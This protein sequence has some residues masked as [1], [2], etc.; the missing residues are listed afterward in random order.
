MERSFKSQGVD[1]TIRETDDKVELE[2][3]GHPISVTKIDER[4]H[5]QLAHMFRSFETVEEVVDTLLRNEGRYWKLEGP[6]AGSGHGGH[7]R[8]GP[9]PPRPGE[10]GGPQS[11]EHQPAEHEHEHEHEHGHDDPSHGEL[12]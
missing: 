6:T 7:D 4:Y 9:I 10:A 1:V 5:S 11:G 12:G 2:L 3:N 8:P